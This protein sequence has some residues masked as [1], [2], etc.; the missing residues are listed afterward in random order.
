M[1]YVFVLVCLSCVVS[2]HFQ[3]LICIILLL[4]CFFVTRLSGLIVCILWSFFLFCFFVVLFW[5]L[6]FFVV[7]IPLKKGPP[8]KP[9]TAKTQKSKNAEKPDKKKSV[10]AVVFTDSVLN[11]LG[12]TM[13]IVVSASFQTGKNTQKL[14]KMLSQNLV[15]G[16]VK[17][18]SKYVAQQNWTKLWLKNGVFFC[19]FFC[20][21]FFE[22]SFSLQKEEGFL[23]NKKRKKKRKL[24][25][26]FDSKKGYFGPSF[27][28]TAYIYACIHV[29]VGRRTNVQQ[30][31]CKMVWPFSFYF[32]LF[33]FRLFE[34][35]Q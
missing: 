3:D 18:W 28:S 8:K 6:S 24:G 35:E 22:I 2:F 19:L 10:S 15:Q 23:K 33:S 13:E 16:W 5:I 11:F 20:S 7:F 14:A 30:L 25:P 27:D 32:L 12:D 17:T 26:S 34:L 1:F 9:D 29:V 4:C 21:F 31:T